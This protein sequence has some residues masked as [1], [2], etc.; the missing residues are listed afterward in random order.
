MNNK[1][2]LQFSTKQICVT[3]VM[4]TFI[5]LMTMIPRIPIPLGYAHL[6]YAAIFWCV[7]VILTHLHTDHASG[8]RMLNDA[9]HIMASEEEIR[10]TKEY[11]IRYVKS[12]WKGVSFEPFAFS[13][14]GV[15]P[16]GKSYDLFDD[17]SVELIQIPGHTSGL[18][19]VKINT[20]DKYVL[21]FSDGGYASKSWKEMVP[22]GT[23]LDEKQALN[24][25]KWIRDMSLNENCVESLANHDADIVP[26]TVELEQ[27]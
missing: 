6:G 16:V 21:L 24:S 13:D 12:M 19:A 10:D 1:P 7:Y 5:F 8:L 18:T 22:P 23:A 4:V 9:K 14:T 26:H 15:G 2:V 11:P 3:A 17:G 20:G 25:L 27:V